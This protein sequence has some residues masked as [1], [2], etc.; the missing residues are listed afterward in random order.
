MVSF[1]IKGAPKAKERPRF[2]VRKGKVLTY[3]PKT[4]ASFEN[5][6]RLRAGEEFTHPIEGSV[7][8]AIRFYLPRPQRLIWKTKQMPEVYCDKRPDI[9]NLAKSVIDGLTGVAFKDDAQIADLH[10]TKMYHAG[11][12]GPK[13][14]VIIDPVQQ[15][16]DQ[17]TLSGDTHKE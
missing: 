10:I 2:T 11:K 1:I 13:T 7:S 12:S 8:L 14:I 17:T 4:T 16:L 15:T 5:I 9:D 6:V 3:T